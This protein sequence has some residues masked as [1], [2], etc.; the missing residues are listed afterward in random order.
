M[1]YDFWY[2]GGSPVRADMPGGGGRPGMPRLDNARHS[3]HLFG[4]RMR[5]PP[6][7][8]VMAAR[9][10]ERR[11]TSPVPSMPVDAAIGGAGLFCG[12]SGE[13]AMNSPIP[14]SVTIPEAARLLG[15]GKTMLY[16]EIAAGRIEARKAGRRTLVSVA[17][18][19]AWFEALPTTPYNIRHKSALLGDQ[20]FGGF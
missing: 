11:Y 16:N 8:S 15:I 6:D 14:I 3:R 9:P 13:S 7:A 19:K 10:S 4:D 2:I 18:L 20:G 5:F 17:V 12:G 1:R